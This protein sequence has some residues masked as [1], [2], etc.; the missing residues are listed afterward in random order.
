[1][2]Q[3]PWSLVRYVFLELLHMMPAGRPW[4]AGAGLLG[5]FASTFFRPV[6]F[7]S[8][9]LSFFLSTHLITGISPHY[10]RLRLN[11]WFGF[12]RFS[13]RSG[14]IEWT[15]VKTRV[16]KW[17]YYVSQNQNEYRVCRQEGEGKWGEVGWEGKAGVLKCN[18]MFHKIKMGSMIKPS[19]TIFYLLS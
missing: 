14:F 3:P 17:I 7:V 1:M 2:Y 11:F 16:V 12:V 9:F 19:G 4:Q 13:N 15:V 8:F 18:I 5:L 10:F 6:S